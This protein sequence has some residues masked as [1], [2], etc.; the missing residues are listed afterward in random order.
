MVNNNKSWQLS[1]GKSLLQQDCSILLTSNG[2]MLS[3]SVKR[4]EL[5]FFVYIS[6]Y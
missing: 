4:V 5:S 1:G 2:Y 3:F 6:L